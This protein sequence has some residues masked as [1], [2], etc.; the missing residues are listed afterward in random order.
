MARLIR[1]QVPDMV[2]AA[3][4]GELSA[5]NLQSFDDAVLRFIVGSSTQDLATYVRWH[6]SRHE[7]RQT[8][9]SY[10]AVPAETC[11][12]GPADAEPAAQPALRV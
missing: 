12:A 1:N 5:P 7:Y 11:S 9:T 2:V 8:L 10:V 6:G 3:D 4:A